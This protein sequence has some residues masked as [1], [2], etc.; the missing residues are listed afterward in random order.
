MTTGG[1]FGASVPKNLRAVTE[2][3]TL[4]KTRTD[5]TPAC[6]VHGARNPF[7]IFGDLLRL[8]SSRGKLLL[9]HSLFR[10]LGSEAKERITLN[11]A[12]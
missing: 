10:L 4:P 12:T 11:V 5:E 8:S 3:D 2:A 6:S 9:P 1:S 7:E